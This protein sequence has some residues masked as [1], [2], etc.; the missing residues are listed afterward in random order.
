[1]ARAPDLTD[2][3]PLNQIIHIWPYKNL[4]ERDRI[5]A[6]AVADGSWPARNAHL[7]RG[8]RSDIMIPLAI[9]PAIVP[10]DLGPYFEI[11]TETYETGEL[12]RIIT[13]WER[14][15]Q[16]LLKVSPVCALWYSELGGLNT[17]QHV[18][19]YRSLDQRRK[20]REQLKSSGLW[21]VYGRNPSD[22]AYRLKAIES[23]IVMPA[24]FSPLR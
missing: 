11:V 15:I 24:E 22:R 5:R 1:M 6:A 21:P 2:I 3:G 10:S 18:W 13:A 19:P 12:A 23:K 20:V 9:M 8:M 7:I 17:F 16:A 14:S 4:E